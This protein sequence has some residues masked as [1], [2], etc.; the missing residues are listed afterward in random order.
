M[1]GL[2]RDLQQRLNFEK[3][4]ALT[5][6]KLADWIEANNHKQSWQWQWELYEQLISPLQ[7][8]INLL[9]YQPNLAI[10]ANNPDEDSNY[11][12]PF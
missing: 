6:C 4:Y 12:I 5:P 8:E 1:S 7:R 3:A 10:T 9:R 11:G 2:E